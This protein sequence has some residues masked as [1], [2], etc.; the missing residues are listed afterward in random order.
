MKSA[1]R[2]SFY[3]DFFF[4]L[5]ALSRLVLVVDNSSIEI[6]RTKV[7]DALAFA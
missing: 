3:S 7:V 1:K 5:D 2:D 4:Q 6:S